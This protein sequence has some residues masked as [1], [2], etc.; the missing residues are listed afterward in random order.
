[1]VVMSEQT[2]ERVKEIKRS[3]R[4]MM[5]GVVAQSMR[6]KGLEYRINWGASL[7][8]LKD[9]AREIG[10]DYDLAI[11]LWKEDVRECK[12]LAT[13][14]MPPSRMLPEV[15]DI[16]MEQTVS[17][18]IAEL[19]SFNLYQYLPYAAS[20]AY[21]WIA[22]D[23][24]IYQLC[25]FNVLSR[26]FMNGQEPNER[27]INEYIDQLTTALQGGRMA[28]RKAAMASAMRF[29]DL[30]LVYKRLVESALKRIN[31]ELF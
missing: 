13:L 18:E 22:S 12:I 25:G 21:Q 31:L 17:R 9:K 1:M 4:M 11:A 19:A 2:N 16:W 28:V 3:F 29:A 30:G 10:Q 20:K 8:M 7:P 5:N 26:L 6:D 23:K 27:G 14:I 24:D 15:V